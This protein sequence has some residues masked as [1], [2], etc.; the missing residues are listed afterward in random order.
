MRIDGADRHELLLIL[1]GT[2][3]PPHLLELLG[4]PSGTERLRVV[5]SVSEAAAA[6]PE[7]LD[8]ILLASGADVGS[9]LAALDALTAMA[10]AAAVVVLTSEASA[11]SGLALA[12]GAQDV[13]PMS[14]LDRSLLM[15]TVR[16]AVERKRALSNLVLLQ[17]NEARSAERSRLERGLLPRP[18]VRDQ[19]LRCVTLYRP[20]AEQAL[21]GGDFY[22]VIE[23]SD[24]TVRVVLGDVAGHGPDEAALGVR[25]RVAWRTLTL[26]DQGLDTFAFLE[27]VLHTERQNAE[28]FVT[29]C[30]VEVAADRRSARLR[31]AGHPL[32]FLLSHR[33]T[34]EAVVARVTPPLGV[35]DEGAWP[36]VDLDLTGADSLLLYTDGLVEGRAAPGSSERLGADALAEVLSAG[37]ARGNS[38]EVLVV[39]ALEEAERRHGGALPDDVAVLGLS[40]GR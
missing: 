40:L 31:S 6:L 5:R 17:E 1:H 19:Q 35:M 3:T 36:F 11:M 30:E 39:A 25:L 29:V 18:L 37:L 2:T 14:P 22:D 9:T 7:E 38:L 21:L 27:R 16:Y 4:E 8:C 20:G 33:G 23:Q 26:A 10:P 24:G 15:R 32:P 28:G 12:A 13:L 34:A